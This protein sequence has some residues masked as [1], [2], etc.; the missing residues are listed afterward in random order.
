MA[1][2]PP[3]PDNR[4]PG[5]PAELLLAKI[6]ERS[7]DA[8]VSHDVDG[9]ITMW[10][11]GAE[12]LFGYRAD[13][14]L[15]Q[16]VTFLVPAHRLSEERDVLERVQRGECSAPYETSRQRRDGQEVN[17]SVAISP[18]Q[19]A[20]GRV[21]GALHLVRDIS[22][23]KRADGA[24]FL[25]AA[26]VNSSD[27]AI[28]SKNLSGIITSWNDAAQ[29][30][31]GYSAHEAI[32]RP[33]S[34]LVP[35]DR[36]DEETRILERLRRGE[37]IDH[38]QTTR[39]RK[40]GEEFPVSLT[41]SPMKDATG[42]IVGASK[43]VRD[44]TLLKR[45]ATEREQLLQHERTARIHAEQVS[46]LK[47]EFLATASHELRTPLNAIV[48]W[49]QVLK[50]VGGHIEDIRAG[51]EVIERN[52]RAQA[53]LIDDLLDLGRISAGKL[54]LEMEPLDVGLL[55]GNAVASLRPAAELKQIDLRSVTTRAGDLTMVGDKRRLQQVLWN[56]L[57]NAIKFTPVAGKVTVS[58]KCM[59]SH[60]EITVA[61]TGCG[62]AADF[63]PHV[64]ERFRQADASTTRQHG[65][66]GIGLALVKQLVELHEG[67]VRAESPGLGQGATFT[68]SF[69]RTAASRAAPRDS[70]PHAADGAGTEDLRGIRVLVVDD[71][72]DSL[73]AIKRILAG[74]H[75]EVETALSVDDALAIFPA[76]R[77]DVVLSD[78]GMPRRDGYE[79]I[80]RI[81]ALPGG[82]V[83]AAALTALARSEDRTQAF[84][85]GFQSHVTK[86]L[87]PG[88]LTAVVYSL[89][90]LQSPAQKRAVP[91]PD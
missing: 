50:D 59:D 33:V 9:L 54:S 40:N 90:R 48:G 76:F 34:M 63:L 6:L 68:L 56:L 29:R 71:D 39:L 45:I 87:S 79:L 4:V 70:D 32:G 49:T 5:L 19:A 8:I 77:P 58:T 24:A 89:A 42:K 51:L 82:E 44:I 37:R 23:R 30:V 28:I 27:D 66:L 84:Q 3:P 14:A 81:R 75:V 61:D 80:R 62:I 91:R 46:R 85:A 69:P 88:E 52:A 31:F 11:D 21:A 73:S 10:N 78:I 55:V 22:D 2:V 53:Q 47:D 12:R 65:G 35:P 36:H 64:F 83:P 72:P 67:G 20:D 60:I 13:E 1:T 18:L 7:E 41:I 74:R 25:L 16:P 43:I 26:I 57:S 86:P 38:F 15:G 17:V